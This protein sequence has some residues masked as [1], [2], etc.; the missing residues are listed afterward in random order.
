[1][2]WEV[3]AFCTNNICNK[4]KNPSVFRHR[5]RCKL[6]AELK[7]KHLHTGN[8]SSVPQIRMGKEVH[9]SGE[10]GRQEGRGENWNTIILT[11]N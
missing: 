4:A 3:L 5:S 9:N 10:N 2:D 7:A 6:S 8:N 1:M 11:S